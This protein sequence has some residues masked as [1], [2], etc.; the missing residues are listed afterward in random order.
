M[1]EDQK[2]EDQDEEGIHLSLSESR[3]PKAAERCN[4]TSCSYH[5]HLRKKENDQ[6]FVLTEL[7]IVMKWTMM[8][9]RIEGDLPA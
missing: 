3:L 4:P 5:D 9:T 8:G 2:R 1:D 6:N 7:T